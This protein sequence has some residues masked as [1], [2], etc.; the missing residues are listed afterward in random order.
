MQVHGNDLLFDNGFGE[1]HELT[2][3]WLQ[4]QCQVHGLTFLEW[5]SLILSHELHASLLG[6]RGRSPHKCTSDCPRQALLCPYFASVH[7]VPQPW[8]GWAVIL[9]YHL[10]EH[11]LVTIVD[12]GKRGVLGTSSSNLHY[13][14]MHHKRLSLRWLTGERVLA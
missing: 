6:A 8:C 4:A 11:R 13:R 3:Q 14:P 1:Y 12:A 10:H 9:E 2:H 5:H 7:H